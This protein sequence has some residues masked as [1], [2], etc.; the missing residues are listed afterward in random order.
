MVTI[1][2]FSGHGLD[3]EEALKIGNGT[4]MSTDSSEVIWLRR[5]EGHESYQ[6]EIEAYNDGQREFPLSKS[7][8]SL[9]QVEEEL[10]HYFHYPAL[11]W[12]Y[13][14]HDPDGH[15]IHFGEPGRNP[16]GTWQN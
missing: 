2:R 4:A 15:T 1:P 8:L 7:G 3:I 16:D 10:N 13:P 14:L 9:D 5:Q 6:L 11:D 12:Y